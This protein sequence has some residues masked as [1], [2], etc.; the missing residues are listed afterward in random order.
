ML[1][2][3]IRSI[4]NSKSNVGSSI[5]NLIHD[6]TKMANIFNNV[7]VNTAHEINEQIPRTRKSPTDCLS[8]SNTDSFFIAAA[9]PKEIKIIINSIKN[10]N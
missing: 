9:T 1:W 7:F 5:T 4:V 3:G 10:E 2:S 8:S 6:G